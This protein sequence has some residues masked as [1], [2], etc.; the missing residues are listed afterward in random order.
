[1]APPA[2][3]PQPRDPLP[4][5]RSELGCLLRDPATPGWEG[6]GSRW[7]GKPDGEETLGVTGPGGGVGPRVSFLMLTF[8]AVV[9][10]YVQSLLPADLESRLGWGRGEAAARAGP[11]PSLEAGCHGTQVRRQVGGHAAGTGHGGQE[12]QAYYPPLSWGTC[13]PL[14]G[15]GAD[16]VRPEPLHLRLLASGPP[17]HGHCGLPTC[18]SSAASP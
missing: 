16:Q 13:P 8:C 11:G 1:M 17:S 12:A 18:A 9:M 2:G 7:T 15:G 14:P 10:L 6:W 5:L 4:C 3:G